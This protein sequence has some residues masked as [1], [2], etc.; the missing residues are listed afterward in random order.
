MERFIHIPHRVP[1]GNARIKHYRGR[2]LILSHCPQ[3]CAHLLRQPRFPR[4]HLLGVLPPGVT[5]DQAPELAQHGIE[6]LS[7]RDAL[8][9]SKREVEEK[10]PRG[11]FGRGGPPRGAPRC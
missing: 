2:V 11:R 9:V 6:L 7:R 8:R 1:F 3:V 4:G 10:L 5:T